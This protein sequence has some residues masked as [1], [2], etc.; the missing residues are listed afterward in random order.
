MVKDGFEVKP[1]LDKFNETSYPGAFRILKGA[2]KSASDQK[3]CKVTDFEILMTRLDNLMPYD[4]RHKVIQELELLY[5]ELKQLFVKQIKSAIDEGLKGK[6]GESLNSINEF[7]KYCISNQIDCVTFNYDDLLDRALFKC[8]ISSKTNIC[9]PSWY[10]DGGYGFYCPPAHSLVLNETDYM[11]VTTMFLLKLHG[12]INWRIKMGASEILGP[13][14]LVHKADWLE[15]PSHFEVTKTTQK[16]DELMENHLKPEGFMVLPVLMKGDL[17]TQPIF[18]LIWG[19]A[20]EKL[21]QADEVFIVG[22]SL[23][24]SDIAARFLFK[25]TLSHKQ[26]ISVINRAIEDKDKESIKSNYRDVFPWLSDKNFNFKGA[27][28]WCSD[29]IK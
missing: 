17:K 27:K 16:M 6:N 26:Y 9:N 19:L 21:V 18:R 28:A 24:N 2:I 4:F 22:Y 11:D 15:P 25:E 3:G 8:G 29:F 5:H 14:D 23:P 12:S 20:Y 7:V 1:L 10:P 13:E